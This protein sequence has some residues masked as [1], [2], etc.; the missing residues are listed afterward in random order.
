MLIGSSRG[1]TPLVLEPVSQPRHT[2]I[3]VRRHHFG[4]TDVI[5]ERREAA[6]KT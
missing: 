1:F 2:G 3:R 4:L 6:A 5:H